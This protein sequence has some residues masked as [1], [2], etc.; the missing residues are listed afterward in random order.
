MN[1]WLF[2]QRTVLLFIDF[3]HFLLI[4]NLFYFF[5]R[6]QFFSFWW[7]YNRDW[8]RFINFNS[9]FC[10]LFLGALLIEFWTIFWREMG[11]L[12]LI[13]ILLTSFTLLLFIWEGFDGL[14]W[15]LLFFLI[16]ELSETIWLF[17]IFF[18]WSIFTKMIKTF[19]LR[20]TFI[21]IAWS[22]WHNSF[23]YP[24]QFLCNHPKFVIF[25]CFNIWTFFHFSFLCSFWS[26]FIFIFCLPLFKW[27]INIWRG[28][29]LIILPLIFMFWILAMILISL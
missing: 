27:R 17:L 25:H 2:H 16:W 6:L 8:F 24:F 5:L 18:R 9:F 7:T 3:D 13:Y 11:N 19:Y 29:T 10:F 4:L 20:L 14:P 12:A 23:L 21:L 28:M 1:L 22:L 26:I 15:N